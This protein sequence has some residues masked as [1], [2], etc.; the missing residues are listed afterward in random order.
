MWFGKK[1]AMKKIAKAWNLAIS[2]KAREPQPFVAGYVPDTTEG[3]FHMVTLTTTLAL[4]RLRSIEPDGREIADAV[5]RQVFAS[6]DYAL[7]EQG[8]GDSSI[9]RKVRKMGEEFFGLA[10]AVDAALDGAD[11]EAAL[12]D[13]LVRNGITQ[14][15]KAEWLAAWVIQRDAELVQGDVDALRDGTFSWPQA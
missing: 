12:S 11:T 13:V 7:R 2:A 14:A 1:R 9:A 8:V 4:R 3:R 5:Y 10:R 6:F 15:D